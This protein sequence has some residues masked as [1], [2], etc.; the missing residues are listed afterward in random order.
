MKTIEELSKLKVGKSY[1]YNPIKL[2][3][4]KKD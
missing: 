1:C 2:K 4:G 3:N